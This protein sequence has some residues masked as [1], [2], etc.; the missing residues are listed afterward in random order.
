MN[1]TERTQPGDV[2]VTTLLALRQQGLQAKLIA[3]QRNE[4]MMGKAGEVVKAVAGAAYEI[5]LK[6]PARAV[7]SIASLAG[8]V[9]V[10]LFG[11]VAN[12][13]LNLI[14]TV[15]AG[16]GAYQRANPDTD[17]SDPLDAYA[18]RVDEQ[19]RSYTN[20]F[21]SGSYDIQSE[22]VSRA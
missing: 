19:V 20:A 5:G 1:S 6:A 22:V 11:V 3:N 8:S 21:R 17:E 12:T 7:Y 2:D 10:G 18:G 4:F 16:I 9:G 15:M 13:A 14:P